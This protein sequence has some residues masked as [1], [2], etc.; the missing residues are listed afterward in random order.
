MATHAPT[1]KP[2]GGYWESGAGK[3]VLCFNLGQGVEEGGG[4]M[5]VF[6]YSCSFITFLLFQP[7]APCH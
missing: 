1:S 2:V 5:F 3:W 7:M 4:E 6:S